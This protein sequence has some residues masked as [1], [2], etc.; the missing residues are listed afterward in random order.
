[1][2]DPDELDQVEA[3]VTRLLG[4]ASAELLEEAF[5]EISLEI[6]PSAKGK[7]TT[8]LRTLNRYLNSQNVVG[9]GG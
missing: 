4:T 6:P 1:M 8:L 7:A 3:N 5:G 9:A 2:A